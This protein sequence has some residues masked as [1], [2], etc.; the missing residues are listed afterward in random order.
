MTPALQV[1]SMLPATLLDIKPCSTVLDMCAS[2]GNITNIGVDVAATRTVTYYLMHTYKKSRQRHDSIV[3]CIMFTG[4]KTTQLVEKIDINRGLVVANDASPIRCYTLVKRTSQALGAK[5]AS[6]VITCHRA[7]S[8]PPLPRTMPHHSTITHE[9]GEAG[10]AVEGRRTF[11]GGYDRIICDV[12]CSGD[13][14]TRKHPEVFTRWE[15]NPAEPYISLLFFNAQLHYECRSPPSSC[16][17]LHLETLVPLLTH[18][19]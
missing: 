19:L 2:P 13:G 5:A 15:V 9:N 4:S 1:A 14:T 6:L 10:G 18:V 11:S 8:M 16:L 7:Q 12:P 3:D 17:P